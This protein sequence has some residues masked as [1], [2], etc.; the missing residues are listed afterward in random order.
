MSTTNEIT[1][2]HVGDDV[3]YA[4]NND[5][6]YAGKITRITKSKKYI[7]TEGGRKFTKIGNNYYR[8]TRHRYCI[9]F[10]GVKEYRDPHF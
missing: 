4:M 7:Y 1:D 2:Y 8:L 9:M 5:C 10:K 3:S 6:Y